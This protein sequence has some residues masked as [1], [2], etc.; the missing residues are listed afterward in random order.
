MRRA[1]LILLL[2]AAP[3]AAQTTVYLKSGGPYAFVAIGASTATPAVVQTYAA[4][5]LNVGD[6]VTIWGVGASVAGSCVWSNVNGIRLV[7]AVPDS[8]HFAITDLS[9]SNITAAGAWCNGNGSAYGFPAAAVA[10]GG[11]VLP[12]TPVSQPAGWLD[13]PNGAVMRKLALGTNNGLTS[14]V[15]AS[16]VATATTS[17]NHGISVGDK[18]GI[19]GSGT[20]ALNHS[21]NP[22]TVTA[23]TGTTFQFTTS[24]VSNGTYTN[25][26]NT[27]GPAA[28]QDCLRISQLAYA[29]NLWWDE[30]VSKIGSWT[31]TSY[32]HIFDGGTIG[33]GSSGNYDLPRF[34]AAGSLWSLVDPTN[35]IMQGV[36]QYC[37]NHAERFNG[38]SFTANESWDQGGD[39]DG[40]DFA[41]FALQGLSMCYAAA[42]PYLN[43]TQIQTFASKVYSSL[44]DPSPC[45]KTRDQAQGTSLATGSAQASSSSSIT[46]AA[47]DTA[48]NGYY[49]NNVVIGTVSGGTSI[50]LITAYNSSTKVATVASW[51]NGTPSSGQ[52]YTI[53]ATMIISSTASG[54]AT[55]TG[56]NTNF[57]AW[58]VG[59]AIIGGNIIGNAQSGQGFGETESYITAINSD[60][61]LTVINGGALSYTGVS[62]ST[63]TIAWW[64]PQWQAGDCG[65]RWMQN[66]WPGAPVLPSQY[67][68]NGGTLIG[69]NASWVPPQQAVWGGNN[70]NSYYAGWLAMD[71][72][73][74]GDDS[75]AITHLAATQEQWWDYEANFEWNY[76]TGF[77]QSG[78]EYSLNRDYPDL[79]N[80]VAAVERSVPSFPMPDLTAWAAGIDLQKI[81]TVYPDLRAD[82][83]AP[84]QHQPRPARYGTEA[85]DPTPYPYGFQISGW[86]MD[87]GWFLYPSSAQAQMLMSWA[88]HNTCCYYASGVDLYQPTLPWGCWGRSAD[89]I[90]HGRRG[91]GRRLDT[92][93][94]AISVPA[95]LAGGVPAIGL[96]RGDALDWMLQ[97]APGAGCDFA[98]RMEQHERHARPV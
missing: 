23:V 53:Y 85:V 69:V 32:K 35:T 96:E 90:H 15:V 40:N 37:V 44:E 86:H 36:A 95:D 38:V 56:Y 29:G 18:L 45:S 78:A 41:S 11:K 1:L 98:R 9:A 21:G 73:V 61:S 89:R 7:S 49:T 87:P 63:P 80:T 57:T 30:V 65:F 10:G 83:T 25:A 88:K 67:P 47:G 52:A 60:T 93:A 24:G 71:F 46:L 64:V 97:R 74:S 6:T 26:N 33:G 75:R 77:A 14:L 91:R 79:T 17:Y 19:W 54:G 27:C 22:Y 55:V 28:N 72:A 94:D 58:Q 34:W 4:H 31:S 62:T 66:H 68:P 16:N 20:S 13:G 3:A 43:S 81:Y 5:G 8:T 82:A 39:A 50:G 59:D 2:A 12:Y 84:S 48:A 42:R 70:G 92:A 51:S 76:H